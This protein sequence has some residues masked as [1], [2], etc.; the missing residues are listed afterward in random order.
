MYFL[1]ARSALVAGVI[2]V[3]WLASTP[4]VSAQSL[5]LELF[6]QYLDALR[7]Q[8]GIPGLSAAIVNERQIVWERGFGFVDVE[9]ATPALPDTPY[10]IADLSQTFASVVV[11][12]CAERGHLSLDDPMQRWTAL[13]PEPGARVRH[14]LAHSSE[15]VPGSSFKYDSARYAALTPVSEACAGHSYRR[16]LASDILDRLSMR[17]SVPGHDFEQPEAAL[18][19]SWAPETLVRYAAVLKRLAK[20]YKIDNRGKAARSEYPLRGINA[21]TGLISTV[22]DLARYD[23]AL[24]DH[25]LLRPDTLALAW[26]NADAGSGRTLPSGLGWFVQTYNGERVI[27][28]FGLSPDS[29]S[30]LVVKVPGREVTL[31]LLANSDGL[32]APFRLGAGDVTTSL[33]ARLFLRLFV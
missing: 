27:W 6:A 17:D 19:E 32:S 10:P 20:P 9:N 16:T 8:A 25:I 1:K 15:S 5:I 3:G 14:V 2:A 18:R 22:R 4:R 33:F 28:H 11:L 31:I 29:F 13:I 30:S 26:T 12:Q 7:Q 21:S 23:A 24:D